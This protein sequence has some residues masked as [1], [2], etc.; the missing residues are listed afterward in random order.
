MGSRRAFED[1]FVCCWKPSFIESR[2]P[3]PGGISRHAR[4]AC[5]QRLWRHSFS[6]PK[7]PDL[8]GY[9]EARYDS[10]VAGL[11]AWG[12]AAVLL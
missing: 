12:C 5:V 8:R 7:C 2:E 9:L 3:L 11:R 1:G 4:S 10:L 6:S